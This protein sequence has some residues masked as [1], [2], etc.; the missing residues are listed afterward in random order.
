VT[1]QNCAIGCELK[2][3]AEWLEV[4]EEAAVEMGLKASDYPFW[5]DLLTLLFKQINK[6]D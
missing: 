2:T 3:H 4:T 5:K 6:G 1:K